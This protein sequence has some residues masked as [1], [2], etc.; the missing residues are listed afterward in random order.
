VPKAI[1]T[2][3]SGAEIVTP[4]T[5]SPCCKFAITEAS[6][7]L[8]KQQD[9]RG[10]VDSGHV[11]RPACSEFRRYG[12]MIWI[13]SVGGPTGGLT[14]SKQHLIIH[15]DCMFDYTEC[16]ITIIQLFV[17]ATNLQ[18]AYDHVKHPKFL[19]GEWSQGKVLKTF[20]DDFRYDGA[21]CNAVH[22]DKQCERISKQ[23]FLDYYR[24]YSTVIDKDVNFDYMMRNNWK[25]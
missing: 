6:F 10:N 5:R 19:N 23:E 13:T 4:P 17:T 15:F 1:R 11:L 21:Y 8:I 12:C 24:G 20:V 18:A 9:V 14:H 25:I 7:F 16:R 22:G 3:R 2:I